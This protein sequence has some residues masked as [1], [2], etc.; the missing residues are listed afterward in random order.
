LIFDARQNGHGSGCRVCGKPIPAECKTTK[1][2]CSRRHKRKAAEI[3]RRGGVLPVVEP[4]TCPVCLGTF[5]VF[6]T[7]PLTCSSAC[8][9]KLK[10][11]YEVFQE[12]TAGPRRQWRGW[13]GGRL[14]VDPARPD[15][16]SI[17]LLLAEHNRLNVY[18]NASD[19]LVE[20]G[21]PRP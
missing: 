4:G 10:T 3:R 2:Y 19:E 17:V 9:K 11:S 6:T 8:A 20:V 18:R 5:A 1:T 12:M 7:E 16:D 14:G 13:I 21:D 15:L